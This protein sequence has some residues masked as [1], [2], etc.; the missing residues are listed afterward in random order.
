MVVIDEL[1]FIWTMPTI[2]WQLDFCLCFLSLD[3][4][5]SLDSR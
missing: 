3:D 2:H 5:L 4:C 1:T